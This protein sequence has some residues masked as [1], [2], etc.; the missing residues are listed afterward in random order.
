[1][2]KKF[3]NVIHVTREGEG[4]DEYLSVSETGVSGLAEAGSSKPCAIYKLVEVGEI[5][6]PPP[7]FV[8]KRKLRS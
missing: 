6:A 5:V 2:K 1:M 4:K 7:A 8:S 3:P